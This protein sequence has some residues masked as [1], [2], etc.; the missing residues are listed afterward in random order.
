MEEEEEEEEEEE[1]E[2]EEE[3]RAPSSA[4]PD[5]PEQ[6]MTPGGATDTILVFNLNKDLVGELAL[7]AEG[8][9]CV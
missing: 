3:S 7:S 9:L 8:T 5:C 6:T 1:G 4:L 2:E